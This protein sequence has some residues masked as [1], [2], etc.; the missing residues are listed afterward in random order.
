MD[1]GQHGGVESH[2][3]QPHGALGLCDSELRVCIQHTTRAISR[4]TS[5]GMMMCFAM[6]DGCVCC[7]ICVKCHIVVLCG[8]GSR[9][10]LAQRAA[11]SGRPALWHALP[12]GPPRG[13]KKPVFMYI[14]GRLP[15]VLLLSRHT[16]NRS[17]KTLILV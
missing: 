12:R 7:V 15:T 10:S 9:A 13:Q 17:N 1:L 4:G 16:Q 11:H 5:R 2:T 6:Y 8:V 3:A 14:S